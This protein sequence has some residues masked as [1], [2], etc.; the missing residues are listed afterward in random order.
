MKFAGFTLALAGL[1][2]GCALG[3]TPN[4][5]QLANI[6]SWTPAGLPNYGTARGSIFAVFGTNLSSTTVPLQ[7][8]PLQTT[9]SSVTLNVTVG[10]ITKQPLLYYL[11]PTQINA[12]LPSSTPVGTGTLTVTNGGGT[13]PGF[14]IK[15]VE[16]AFGLLTFNYGSGPLAGFNASNDGAYLGFLAAAN[17]GDVLE[18][19]GT[20]LGPVADDAVGG[21]VSD[22]AVVFIGGVAVT[23]HISGP[24]VVHGLD[25]I[26]V[27]VPAGLSGCYV[28]VVV[29]TGNFVSNF[30]TLPVA[31]S[32]RTCTDPT[33]PYH[34]M[35]N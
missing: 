8:G 6:Y 10:G 31:G 22:P 1:F 35:I 15:V 20:G 26:N 13:S 30:G 23:P 29:Q 12:V 19:W 17:P 7:S 18:L 2:A 5:T 28:S 14:P 32:G 21:P 9:L 34:R 11:S 16:S 24:F 3:Q 27:Q 25:Q 33:I 4:V